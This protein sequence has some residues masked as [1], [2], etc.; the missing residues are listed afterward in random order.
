MGRQDEETMMATTD[1]K[2]M[3]TRVAAKA[4]VNISGWTSRACTAERVVGVGAAVA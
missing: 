1:V 3:L 4:G 2:L